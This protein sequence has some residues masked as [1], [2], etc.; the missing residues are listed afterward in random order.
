MESSRQ[1]SQYLLKSHKNLFSSILYIIYNKNLLEIIIIVDSRDLK[2]RFID[3]I[4]YIIKKLSIESNIEKLRK[5]LKEIN[6]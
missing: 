5:I 2:L 6:I 3:N 4:A 1:L